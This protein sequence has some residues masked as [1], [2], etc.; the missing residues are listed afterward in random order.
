[1]L[2]TLTHGSHTDYSGSIVKRIYPKGIEY[3]CN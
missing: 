2:S 1:M 3:H